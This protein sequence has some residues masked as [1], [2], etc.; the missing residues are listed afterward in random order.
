M[1]KFFEAFSCENFSKNFSLKPRIEKSDFFGLSSDF[2][3]DFWA[4]IYKSITYMPLG[5]RKPDGTHDSIR[6][7]LQK[8]KLKFE[9]Q[10]PNVD[11]KLSS[12]KV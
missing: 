6:P 12:L 8:P 5:T 1:F 11:A 9:L 10:R 3:R 7:K 4:T 2:G